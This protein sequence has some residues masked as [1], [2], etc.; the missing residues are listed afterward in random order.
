MKPVEV[1]DSVPT[2]DEIEDVVKKFRR[3]RSE[4]SSR[5]RSEHLKGFLAG[6]NRGKKAA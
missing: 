6:S 5:M 3:N 1:D 2:E 4:G